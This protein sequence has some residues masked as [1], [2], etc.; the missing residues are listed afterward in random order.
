MDRFHTS[1]VCSFTKEANFDLSIT[2]ECHWAPL[3]TGWWRKEQQ[4]VLELKEG[5]AWPP[6]VFEECQKVLISV[7]LWCPLLRDPM[8]LDQEPEFIQGAN[9]GI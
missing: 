3:A 7:H 4:N 5:T 9:E 2:G 6:D 8:C 1:A